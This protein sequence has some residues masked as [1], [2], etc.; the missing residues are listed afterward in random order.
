MR[1]CADAPDHP[2]WRWRDRV[3]DNAGPMAHETTVLDVGCGE[4]LIG[5][6]ALERGA[7]DVVFSDISSDLLGVCRARALELGIADRCRFVQAPAEH[8]G[9][10]ESESVDVAATRSVLIYVADKAAAF[11]ELARVLRPEGRVSLFE[12]INRF[13][14][15]SGD[16]WAGYDLSAIPKISRKVRAVYDELQPPDTDPM[17]DFDERDLV[18]L[19][20]A[21]GFFPIHLELSAEIERTKP[22][23]WDDFVSRAW[24]PR[25]PSLLDVMEQTLTSGEREQLTA[26]LGPLVEAGAG[27]HRMALALLWGTKA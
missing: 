19:A 22:V 18:R 16:T 3:L 6:G 8:L 4:G 1:P 15:T 17:L 9:P 20:E 12:P 5:F 11:R 21:S 26:H 10:I 13:A 25:I 2:H 7:G 24:N 23:D 27:V 14:R